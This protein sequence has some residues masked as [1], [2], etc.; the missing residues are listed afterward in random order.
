MIDWSEHIQ[1]NTE[2]CNIPSDALA[3]I[4]MPR[5]SLPCPPTEQRPDERQQTRKN[6][7]V[8][9]LLL[10]LLLLQM[11]DYTTRGKER[12][13]KISM[14]SNSS[15]KFSQWQWHHKEKARSNKLNK[16]TIELQLLLVAS[17]RKTHKYMPKIHG[18]EH[19]P[20]WQTCALLPGKSKG[21][22]HLIIARDTYH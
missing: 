2:S 21:S 22:I 18:S 20:S 15:L 10:N 11:L 9:A 5:N 1:N 8:H 16:A 19:L 12:Q 6:A 14:S 13:E 3:G 17:T 4:H 7:E